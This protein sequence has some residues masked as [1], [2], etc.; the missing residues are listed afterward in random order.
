MTDE[1]QKTEVP[2]T[3]Y[4]QPKPVGMHVLGILQI[5]QTKKPCWL[6]RVMLNLVFGIKWEDF[7][8]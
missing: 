8:D 1:H 2:L 4:N 5:H 3:F 6:H 7:H